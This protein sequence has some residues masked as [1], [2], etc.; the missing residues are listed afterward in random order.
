MLFTPSQ[1]IASTNVTKNIT[2]NTIWNISGSPYNINST[3]QV[4]ENVTLTIQ[5]GVEVEFGETARLEIGG[6]LIARGTESS[7]ITFSSS[8]TVTKNTNRGIIFL[9]TAPSSAYKSGPRPRFVYDYDNKLLR[10]EY[11]NSYGYESGS[12]LEYCLLDNLD[13]AISTI[14]TLPCVIN[15][16]IKNSTHGIHLS[17][18]PSIPEYKWFFFYNNTV[19]NCEIAIYSEWYN[20][21][22]LGL[23][24]GNT[25]KNCTSQIGY[26][27]VGFT[28][29]RSC[30]FLIKNQI[31]NNAN[32]AFGNLVT[33]YEGWPY[34]PSDDRFEI[35]MFIEHNSITHN[36]SGVAASGYVA[37]LHN[38]IAENDLSTSKVLGAGAFLT[39]PVGM[40]FNNSIQLNGVSGVLGSHGDGIALPSLETNFFVINHNN[41]GN[42]VW[43]MQDIYI[44]P[45]TNNCSTSKLMNVDAKLNSWNT[46]NPSDHIYDQKDN[47]CSGTVDYLP[48]RSSAMVPAPINAYPALRS[49]EDNAYFAGQTSF[50]FSW[51]PVAQATKYMIFVLGDDSEHKLNKIEMVNTTSVDIDFTTDLSFNYGIKEFHW[52]VVAGNDD[53][54]SLPSEVRKVTFS[55]DT[56]LVTG[57]V[58][59]EYENPVAGVYV[60]Y[61]SYTL[62]YSL[63]DENGN[64]SLI[65]EDGYGGDIFT[66]SYLIKKRGYVTCYTYPRG[67]REFDVAGDLIIISIAKR[68]AI[69]N[70]VGITRDTKK[71][72][73]AGVVVNDK[74]QAL[75]GAEVTINPSSGIVYYIDDNGNPDLSLTKTG[76]SGKF[77]IL[78]VTPGNY[79]LTAT[80]EGYTFSPTISVYE[81]AITA[82]ALI[83]ESSSS[84]GDGGS[85]GDDGGGGGCFI[86]TAAYGSLMEPHVKILRDFRDRYLLG[87]T[88]GDNFVRLYYIYSPP[89]AD[90]ISKYDSLKAM[91]RISLLPVVGLSWVALKIAPLPTVALMLFF[92]SFFVGLFWFRRIYRG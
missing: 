69:Y 41:L 66:K 49:P 78:N 91:V 1:I 32:I 54:W 81:G 74:D 11:D 15:S 88:I 82:D 71:G 53:G 22:V 10:L 3:I 79:E 24:S 20:D 61:P 65:P 56:V 62:V 75:V 89:I 4:Y 58:L 2:Q 44:V 86:A 90:F 37:L 28:G 70:A 36:Y 45:D 14:D 64:Y 19:E 26:P 30:V 83:A 68:D 21:R 50:T 23:I 6:Q 5:P 73:I 63:S 72:D 35:L 12:I 60:G 67:Q 7:V 40:V 27:T 46:A 16:T 76:S 13:K 77:I 38:Y 48:V 92:I 84:G 8:S 80:L 29:V 9:E 18:N 55:P 47:T 52:F 34:D 39:G 87:N 57:K 33:Y 59:D 17:H 43:D 42:S 85:T 25:F 51:E 31:I